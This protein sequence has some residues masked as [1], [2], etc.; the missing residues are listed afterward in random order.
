MDAAIRQLDEA[1]L[2]AVAGGGVLSDLGKIGWGLAGGL[3]GGPVG[4]AAS[5]AF[6]VVANGVLDSTSPS[7][8]EGLGQPM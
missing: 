5:V 4:A 6:F 1:E 8:G 3:V 7:S 2:T